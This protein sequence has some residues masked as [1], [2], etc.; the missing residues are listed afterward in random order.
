ML[1]T[2]ELQNITFKHYDWEKSN[3]EKQIELFR[4]DKLFFLKA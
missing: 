4:I 3:L 1:Q 2:T